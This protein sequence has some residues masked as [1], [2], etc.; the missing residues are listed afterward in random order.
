[1]RS[2]TDEFFA[3]EGRPLNRPRTVF[4][5]GDRKQSIYS[6]QGADPDVFLNVHDEFK[7]RAESA[8]A[9]FGDVDFTVSFRSVQ[10]VLSAV[11]EVFQPQANARR[12]LAGRDRPARDWNHEST[13]RPAEGVVEIWPLMAPLESEDGDPWQAPVDRE[14]MQS[15]RRRLALH[16]ARTI[17]GWI[18]RRVIVAL[19][20]AVRP[21]DVLILV[22][23]RNVFFDALIRALWTEGVPVAGADRL[24]L[25]ENIAVLDL[26]ALAQFSLM[27]EDDHSLACLLKSPLLADPLT[28][29]ELFALAYDRGTASLWQRL[30]ESDLPRCKAAVDTLS[31]LIAAAPS[32]RP[33]EFFSRVLMV[34]RAR[35]LK[36]LGS[37]ANDAIDSFLDMAMTYEESYP[38]SLGGFVNWFTSAEIEIKRN[39]EQGAGEVRIMTVHGAKGLEAPI[40]ILPDT[41]S[42]PDHRNAD[43]LLM[44]P[45][46]LGDAKVPLWPVPNAFE[47]SA[48]GA[49]KSTRQTRQ[50]DEYQRLLYVAMTRAKEEL[51]VCGYQGSRVPPADCWYNTVRTSLEPKM[52]PIA[53][54]EGWRRGAA[55]V[56]RGVGEERAAAPVSL[57]DWLVR[58]FQAQ[59][60]MPEP[61]RPPKEPRTAVRVARGILIHR[62][63]QQIGDLP[64]DARAAHIRQVVSRAGHEQEL[65]DELIALAKRP[66]FAEIFD[67]GGLSEVPLL[68]KAADGQ[69]ERRQIDRLVIGPHDLLV[70]DYKTDRRWPSDPAAV[71]PEYLQQ[72]AA[73]RAALRR[74]HPAAPMRLA[75][76]WTEGPVLMPVTDEILDS[77][78]EAA[79]ISSP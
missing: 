25:G 28:E 54:Y 24:K 65:A 60:V 53:E 35:F 3:G 73:Y 45:A 48:L 34:S 52:I 37:E 11:D 51:Y 19:D 4:V 7:A 78:L 9:R 31:P 39:M 22:R 12:G 14:P 55:P 67:P 21:E 30:G 76:L 50:L 59:M 36:R 26:L 1:I 15:P 69:T 16:L 43:P 79:Q 74:I 2:L 17:K 29:E 32:A 72:L 63:L 13:R 6:F 62:I 49:L 77:H 66:D 61:S 44:L 38:T 20:R 47:S 42:V 46:G 27:T 23:R 41:T 75:I 68:V 18:G 70:V 64:E 10:E 56:Y 71:R 5:V 8:G 57:P 33:F 40:V 58:P